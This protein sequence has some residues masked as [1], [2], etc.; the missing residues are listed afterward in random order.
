MKKRGLSIVFILGFL[1]ITPSCY[2]VASDVGAA[3]FNF[4]N[5]LTIWNFWSLILIAL[6][7]LAWG[8][9]A[10]LGHRFR[11]WVVPTFCTLAVLANVGTF[12][13]I[14]NY[15]NPFSRGNDNSGRNTAQEFTVSAFVN[16]SSLG[17]I[18][19]QRLSAEQDT[20]VTITATPD[21]GNDFGHWEVVSGDVTLRNASSPT[22]SFIMPDHDVS[23]MAH[24]LVPGYAD[25]PGAS[26]PELIPTPTPTPTTM[27]APTPTQDEIYVRTPDLADVILG[28]SDWVWLNINW[29]DGRNTVFERDRNSFVWTMLSRDDNYR[30]VE[31]D[32]SPE[33]SALTIG[34]PTT[35]SRYFLY[36][37]NTGYFGNE[38]LIW[39]FITDPSYSRLSVSGVGQT[40]GLSHALS[41]YLLLVIRV[42]WHNGDITI[43]YM[44]S[45]GSWMM[46]GR[47]GSFMAV[48]PGFGSRSDHVFM[49]F[50]TTSGQYLFYDGGT[51]VFGSESFNWY[52]NF[53][54]G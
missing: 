47:N 12:L 15:G 23:F 13:V 38:T 29:P 45:D 5:G 8:V 53:S 37:D 54:D 2:A 6:I 18:S 44:Q 48:E 27:P 35:Q 7:F 14:N 52:Y 41:R 28:T 17:T 1:F 11:A 49:G 51:G 16:D 32:F 30:I 4:R 40:R 42:Y 34:F 39:D 46:R 36:A 31:P 20:R 33:G 50:P 22:V 43:F 19:A 24:F 26:E 3:S 25:E 9:L 21:F 10:Q